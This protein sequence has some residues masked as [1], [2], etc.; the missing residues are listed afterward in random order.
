MRLVA[1]IFSE[2]EVGAKTSKAD[3]KIWAKIG[4]LSKYRDYGR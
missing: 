4:K 1:R 2:V 3:I